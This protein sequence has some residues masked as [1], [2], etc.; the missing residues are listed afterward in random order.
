MTIM[1]KLAV[2]DY[3]GTIANRGVL[4][5][6][7]VEAFLHLK[8][9]GYHIAICTGRTYVRIK[10]SFGSDYDKIFDQLAILMTDHG[11]R[12]VDYKGND[13]YMADFGVEE[14]EHFIDFIRSNIEI[15]DFIFYSKGSERDGIF[16]TNTD[17]LEEISEQRRY[18]ADITSGN[19]SELK[20][21]LLTMKCTHIGVRLKSHV[22]VHNFVLNFTRTNTKLLF[23]DGAMDFLMAN[24]NKGLALSYVANHFGV[25]NDDILVAGNAINDVEMLNHPAGTRILVGPSAEADQITEYI[26]ESN[27]LLRPKSPEELST[28]LMTL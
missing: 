19:L 7:V 23:Q 12:I 16:V 10:E 9:R 24:S 6:G 1:D 18:Y 25:S 11:S 26:T 27:N 17:K 15:A 21:E 3:D 8:S 22:A 4:A 20:S 14:V 2:F 13:I 5:A 28:F